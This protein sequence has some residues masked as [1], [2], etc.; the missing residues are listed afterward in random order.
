MEDYERI[1]QAAQGYTELGMHDDAL[2]ELDS[3]IPAVRDRPDVLELRVLI[4][5]HA[6]KWNKALAASRE[7]CKVR[8]EVTVGYIHTAFCL[9]ELGRSG[10]AKSVL[11]SG[12][13]A[14][15]D[16]PTYHY[17][18]ACYECVLGNLESAQAHLETSFALDKKFRSFAKTDPDLKLLNL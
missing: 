11:L 4:L 9:H 6:K 14:L 12:P 18:L 8:P 5:M 2:A 15:L 7:L 16:E 10:D 1:I 17:N 3:L 13:A